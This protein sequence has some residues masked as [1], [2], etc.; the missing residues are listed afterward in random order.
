[1]HDE[2]EPMKAVSLFDPE[3]KLCNDNLSTLQT[4]KKFE[5]DERLLNES[6]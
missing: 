1:M 6:E 4:C 5:V 3:D 2:D